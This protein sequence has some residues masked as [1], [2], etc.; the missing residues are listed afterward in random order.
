MTAS[1]AA[2]AGGAAPRSEAAIIDTDIPAR[3]DRLPWGRFHTLVVVA[4][5]ITWILDGLEVTLAGAVSPR[6]QG[7]PA[8]QLLQCRCRACRAA[9]ISPARCSAR[10]SSAGSPTGSG[11]SGCS[12]SRSRSISSP[13]RRPRLSWNLWSFALFRFLTG[14]GIGGEYTAINSTIQELV[15]ARYRGW[16]DLVINGSFWIG[17]ALGAAGSIVLLDPDL[18]APDLGWRAAFLIG[19]VLG[20]VDLPHAPVAAGIAALADDAWPRRGGGG[21]RSTAS[22]PSSARAATRSTPSRCRVIRLRARRSTPLAEVAE[23]LFRVERRRTL[24]RA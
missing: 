18:L 8:A 15:P 20:L 16:T 1:T 12:S 13:P 11:A 4:L 23:T 24:R 5:G 3:L 10:C 9:P 21:D 2:A 22:R 14:A 19:A 6:A 17:A 7:E